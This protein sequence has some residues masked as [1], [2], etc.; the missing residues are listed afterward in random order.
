M[1][2]AVMPLMQIQRCFVVYTRPGK[3]F[4]ASD[5]LDVWLIINHQ[6]EGRRKNTTSKSIIY[7]NVVVVLIISYRNIAKHMA[8]YSSLINYIIN[9][10]LY[11][12]IPID[13]FCDICH[14]RN[15]ACH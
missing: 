7:H 10:A 2:I 12:S 13:P 14:I 15:Y 3:L 5:V 11:A 4:D 6:F 9:D 8:N 1:T